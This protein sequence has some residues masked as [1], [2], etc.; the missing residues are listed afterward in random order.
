M[1]WL[2]SK[3]PYMLLVLLA[4][5]ILVFSIFDVVFDKGWQ[6]VLILS[7]ILII[8]LFFVLILLRANQKLNTYLSIEEF[9][10]TL[11]GGLY[12]FKCP[13]CSGIFAIKKTK[14]NDKKPVKMTCPDCGEIG[15][16]PVNPLCVE[17][18]IP[19]KK[20]LKANF[21]CNACGEGVT[22]WAE[23]T[24]LYDHTTVLSCP[25]CGVKEPLQRF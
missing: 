4:F 2:Y 20:S 14:R 5:W 18:E 8:I 12:H 6:V 22:I 23:G 17:E 15:F 10:K 25:F 21:R 19:E 9:E 16:I 3:A 11:K 7:Y 24:E 1:N 13:K